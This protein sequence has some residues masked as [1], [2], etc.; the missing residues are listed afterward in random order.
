M[1]PST[2]VENFVTLL[3]A[4]SVVEGSYKP[5]PISNLLAN[6]STANTLGYGNLYN[7]G[8]SSALADT[9][10]NASGVSLSSLSSSGGINTSTQCSVVPYN[11]PPLLNQAFWSFDS[12]AAA[13][14]RYRR[15]QSVNLG[16]WFVQENW[17]K[18]TSP[19]VGDLFD[20]ARAVLER[21]W[22]T[23]MNQSDFDYLANM[24]INTVR[25]PMGYWTL[26]PT[27]VTG[28]P[29]EPYASV[30]ENSWPRFV[31]AINM[32]AQANIGVLVDVHGAIGSQNWATALCF[33]IDT[34]AITA[35]RQR[36]S[37]G[38]SLPIY[39]HDGFN[40]DKYSAYLSERTDFVVEDHHS[41]FV[42]TPAD[43]SEPA[44]QHTS[45][46]RENLVINEC[47]STQRDPNEAQKQ[48]CT[49]QMGVYTNTS[50]GWSFWSYN[51]E[52][53]DTDQGWCFKAA[54]GKS[55][56]D[57]FFS[58]GKPPPMDADELQR[59]Y[60]AVASMTVPPQSDILQRLASSPSTVTTRKLT[61]QWNMTAAQ[62][63][64]SIE[65]YSDGYQ[66]A[67]IF[68]Q[69]GWS[70]LGF[71]EQYIRDS[72]SAMS[73]FPSI[74]TEDYYRSGFKAGLADGEAVVTAILS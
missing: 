15:Q 23:F 53:C 7:P 43:E 58:Y 57:T 69:H 16:S 19:P 14:Y 37:G 8:F 49:I 29:F 27:F 5:S 22:D 36:S 50:A 21:H 3:R 12:T 35:M 10:F 24:G 67:K 48:F 68:T 52:S 33:W 17:M 62:Q 28:T 11:P 41:Y 63:Q 44:S 38:V 34:K 6:N 66:T 20:N 61:A 39:I 64:S 31:R 74:E 65:G 55:L 73:G 9:A 71:T 72:L 42:F 54:V 18:S 30:Y 56:P 2:Y 1:S 46:Y 4:L 25:L 13:A 40:L 59:A 51:K 70:R 26:G 32:A 45:D 47:L 60:A